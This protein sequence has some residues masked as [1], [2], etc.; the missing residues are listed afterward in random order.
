MAFLSLLIG[1]SGWSYD[2]WIGPFYEKKTGMFTKYVKVFNTTEINSTFYSYPTERLVTGWVRYAP[3][4]FVFAAKLP[5]LITH[6]K[7]L[8]SEEGVE[9]DLWKFL[10]LMQPLQ[11]KLG[12]I[13]IQLR[14]K[15][16]FETNFS[17]LEKFIEI[18]PT[19]HQ[20]AVEFRHSSW[21]RKETYQLLTKHNVAYTIVD[22]PLLPPEVVIT[23]DFSYIRW[24]GH[25]KKIWYDYEYNE[26]Q[27]K[28]WIPKIEETQ[29]K[30]K[31]TYGYF[32]NHYNANAVKNAI[33]VLQMMNSSTD[34][35]ENILENIIESRT[36]SKEQK[37][38]ILTLTSFQNDDEDLSIADRLIRFTD[39]GRLSRAEKLTDEIII[40]ESTNKMVR[41]K[42]K[43]YYID[44]D[45]VKKTI[46]HNCDDWRK[47][48]NQKRM[49]KHLDF[50]FLKLQPIMS[51]RILDKIW[52]EKDE[53][54]FLE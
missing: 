7:W 16:E 2:E 40:Y 49:C 54:V 51:K 32:N 47:G 52:E 46:K 25:G 12:P 1:T 4:N 37:S 20:W 10:H 26:K 17:D 45:L 44:I 38:N 21:L 3:M 8:K 34:E 18:L 41:A 50:L 15:F 23:A 53:W 39:L 5:Q 19:N 9:D 28:D 29:K 42:I 22:E 31:K 36:K 33:E 27:L 30:V 48:L 6:N 24:H 14:P 13:L 43:N 35:Q 11:E